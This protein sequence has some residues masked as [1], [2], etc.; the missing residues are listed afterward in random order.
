VN[1]KNFVNLDLVCNVEFT[2][3]SCELFFVN[4]TQRSFKG[5]EK[6]LLA[7]T[8]AIKNYYGKG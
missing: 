4:G 1:D 6:E 5:K 3:N 8:L 2:E 7:Q